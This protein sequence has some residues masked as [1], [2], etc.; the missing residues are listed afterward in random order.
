MLPAKPFAGQQGFDN[1]QSE[2]DLSS[3]VPW[4]PSR[5]VRQNA[6][7]SGHPNAAMVD[8]IPGYAPTEQAAIG[9]RR[10]LQRRFYLAQMAR[11]SRLRHHGKRGARQQWRPWPRRTDTGTCGQV[12]AAKTIP[13][14]CLAPGIIEGCIPNQN[15]A[16]IKPRPGQLLGV[17]TQSCHLF[18]PF[19]EASRRSDTRVCRWG[20]GCHK[21]QAP[22]LGAFHQD[23]IG[24]L[25]TGHVFPGAGPPGSRAGHLLAGKPQRGN[26]HSLTKGNTDAENRKRIKFA[27]D[28]AQES[29]LRASN[30]KIIDA[31]TASNSNDCAIRLANALRDS[32]GQRACF[33]S[34]KCRHGSILCWRGSGCHVF[35]PEAFRSAPS[36][37]H[38]TVKTS[39]NKKSPGK[40]APSPVV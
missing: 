17:K 23:P 5:S 19:A 24:D 22:L 16:V 32:P 20:R 12:P 2:S 38:Q 18:G 28:I 40:L 30:P 3:G 7:R 15:L 9:W 35:P 14:E 10:P 29:P 11:Q 1:I 39:F 6:C 26:E 33:C 27:Q 31:L 34:W 8:T 13:D 4:S 21:K 37:S 25:P 36:R